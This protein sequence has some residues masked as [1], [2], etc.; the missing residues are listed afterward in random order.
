MA[1]HI[2][3]VNKISTIPTT[4][5]RSSIGCGA[6]GAVKATCLVADVDCSACLSYWH[7]LKEIERVQYCARYERILKHQEKRRE[8]KKALKNGSYRYLDWRVQIKEES[9]RFVA[10]ARK[11]GREWLI[12]YVTSESDHK[13]IQMRIRE[14]EFKWINGKSLDRYIRDVQ[15]ELSV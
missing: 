14:E 8:L 4:E 2:Y 6:Y 3:K 1:I 10:E 15:E 5:D 12:I 9:G 13:T 7:G 11:P